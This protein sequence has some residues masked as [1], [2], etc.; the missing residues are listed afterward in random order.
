MLKLGRAHVHE[1]GQAQC[2]KIGDY[3]DG[4]DAI[5]FL[6]S[7][8]I[9]VTRRSTIALLMASVLCVSKALPIFTTIRLADNG[10]L[11]FFLIL[12]EDIFKPIDHKG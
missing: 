2:P 12:S 7:I 9:S 10:L 4:I 3:A 8:A 11:K 6:E 1:F 5:E